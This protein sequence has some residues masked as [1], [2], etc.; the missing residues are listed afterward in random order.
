MDI[1]DGS[2]S[3][4]VRLNDKNGRSAGNIDVVLVAYND[5]GRV[6]DFGALEVQAVYVSGNIRRPFREFMRKRTEA[7]DWS[8]QKKHPRLD[9][10]SSSRKRLVPPPIARRPKGVR[11]PGSFPMNLHIYLD[12]IPSQ[13]FREIL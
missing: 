6:V 12:I 4:E 5:K 10:L 13:P 11:C 3:T 2:T 9:Y 1:L 7:F 8:N